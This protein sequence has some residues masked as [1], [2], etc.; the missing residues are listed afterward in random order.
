M[1]VCVPF[2]L[3]CQRVFPEAPRGAR[4]SRDGTNAMLAV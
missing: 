4:S 3:S 1:R 2:L